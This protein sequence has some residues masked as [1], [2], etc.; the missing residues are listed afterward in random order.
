MRGTN[1][2][3]ASAIVDIRSYYLDHR[4]RKIYY[5]EIPG[6]TQRWSV[7]VNDHNLLA[8]AC[9]TAAPKCTIYW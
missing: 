1:R 8:R 2:T 4:F 6:W 5:K 7:M 3:S 9:L